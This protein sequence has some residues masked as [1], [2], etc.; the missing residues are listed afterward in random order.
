[1][2]FCSFL[3]LP[4]WNG[5]ISI[6]SSTASSFSSLRLSSVEF[7][8]V[9]CKLLVAYSKMYVSGY[10]CGTSVARVP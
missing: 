3:I 6:E 5:R 7:V 2:P 8:Q 9:G 10:R 1:M 4:Q